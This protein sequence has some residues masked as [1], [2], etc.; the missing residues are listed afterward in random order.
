[1]KITRMDYEKLG[2]CYYKENFKVTN[3]KVLTNHELDVLERCG[4]LGYGQGFHIGKWEQ[5]SDGW[6]TIVTRTID[7][8]D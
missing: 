7:S 1:M 6:E 2:N 4:K 3:S 8:S 5:T